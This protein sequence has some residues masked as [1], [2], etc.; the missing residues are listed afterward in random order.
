MRLKVA[1]ADGTQ[2]EYL[3]TKV[4]GT[5]SNSLNAAGEDDLELAER[6]AE[7]VTYYLYDRNHCARIESGEIL[8]I[9]RAVLTATEHC[10]AALALIEHR[11]NRKLS[12]SRVEVAPVDVRELSDARAFCA[13]DGCVERVP[14]DKSRIVNYLIERHELERQNARAI[15]SMVE[16]KVLNMNLSLVPASLVKQ[17]VLY[18]AAAVIAAGE[19]LAEEEALAGA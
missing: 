14:W 1:K 12:R 8:G 15:A 10:A 11:L 17:I 7:V 18:Y 9:I 2:E 19:Q 5:I 16:E 3:Y 4:L 6:L 13:A